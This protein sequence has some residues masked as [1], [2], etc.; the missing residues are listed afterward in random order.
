MAENNIFVNI[1]EMD[2][3]A[4]GQTYRRNNT[5]RRL[6]IY[7]QGTTRPSSSFTRIIRENPDIQLPPTNFPY[8]YNTE[9]NRWVQRRNVLDQRRTQPTLKKA[10][11]RDYELVNGRLKKKK[12]YVYSNRINYTIV[13]KP[14][15]RTLTALFTQRTLVVNSR[16][17]ITITREFVAGSVPREM[18]NEYTSDVSDT[19]P[20]DEL[21][22]FTNNIKALQQLRGDI[23]SSTFIIVRSVDSQR[24]EVSQQDIRNMRMFNCKFVLESPNM[25]NKF[26]D[27]GNLSCVPETLHWLYCNPDN[28]DRPLKLSVEDIA[29]ILQPTDYLDEPDEID[30]KQGF[31]TLD[32]KRFCQ[33]YRIPMYACD[34]FN[35]MFETYLPEKRN[36]HMKSLAFMVWG[37]HM[38]LY[39]NTQ[40][41]KRMAK[42]AD[43]KDNVS[44]GLIKGKKELYTE[45]T[46]TDK[47][48]ID[49]TDDLMEEVLN[50]YKQT[51]KILTSDNMTIVNGKITK[52]IIDGVKHFAN[53]EEEVIK[54]YIKQYNETSD[55]TIEFKNQSSM[56]FARMLWKK[57]YPDHIQSKMNT[58]VLNRFTTN[59][60]IVEKYDTTGNIQN[61]YAVD[62]NKCRTSCM[63]DN[64]LGNY[65]RFTAMDS[66]EPYENVENLREGFYYILTE[67]RLPARGNGWYSNGFINYLKKENIEYKIKYQLLA[68]DTYKEDYLM[69]MFDII[70]KYK[71][72]KFMS[73]GLIGSLA[74]KR[75][76]S[77]DMTFETDFNAACFYF[78]NADKSSY[79]L[80]GLKD[81]G[82][83]QKILCQD[84]RTKKETFIR[85]VLWNEEEDKPSLYSIES[86]SYYHMI[87]NDIPIYNQILENEWIKCYKL[88]KAMG[89]NLIQ[90]KTDCVQVEFPKATLDDEDDQ[91]I[92]GI[93]KADSYEVDYVNK[94]YNEELDI[95]FKE[96][97]TT[98]EQDYNGMEDIAKTIIDSDKSCLIHGKA[99]VGKSY[100]LRH[101]VKEL[102]KQGKKYAVLAP[103]NKASLNVNGT[104]IHKFLGIAEDNKVNGSML[105]K[106][107]SYD[108]L[109]VDE[110]SMVG[111]SLLSYLQL[112]KQQTNNLKLLF[113]GD[114]KRQLLPVCEEQY[115]YEN[116]YLMK[117]LCSFN[118]LELTINKRSD[119][120]MMKLSDDAFENGC[121]NKNDFGNFNIWKSNRHICFTNK[122]RK[123]INDIIMH[124]KKGDYLEIQC[125]D[126]DIKKNEYAQNVKIHVGTPIMSCKNCKKDGIV[127]NEEFVVDKWDDEFVYIDNDKKIEITK[128]HS[129]YVVSY[130]MTTHKSQ[131]QT[132]DFKY[133]IWEYDKFT[134]RMLYTALTRTTNKDNI[135]FAK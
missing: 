52:M 113:F 69:K 94:K 91:N 110:I 47:D 68:S 5:G 84:G 132:F 15:R 90:I 76:T 65:K 74:I 100:M 22:R 55:E 31:T 77:S 105:R 120:I 58:Q 8:L 29:E 23:Q 111:C 56:N 81:E 98:Y 106:M 130:A 26:K 4:D 73:N 115:D 36:R 95:T 107:K 51:G 45:E 117:W 93:K 20:D 123:R 118:K 32:I 11:A 125:S 24:V 57:A 41:I 43:M 82:K 60:G 88:R 2:Y 126:D 39:D 54:G 10:Y 124:N 134:P 89:G 6:N 104:T 80:T 28:C 99:G 75:K 21:Q 135:T 42:I 12:E 83:K 66:I 85:P 102:E 49:N 27:T 19:M 46:I 35:Y 40:F 61:S 79:R 16:T 87:E 1:R 97:N 14:S 122:T 34:A 64:I 101:I 18:L 53:T 133:T 96:W 9:T 129:Q 37:N 63:R 108:Y 72:F 33:K 128:F 13:T 25:S 92:G 30:I 17:P 7:R 59:A 103:T 71:D 116:S 119:D 127:N 44:S 86:R 78:W 109:L 3:S 131:G 62:I 48:I 50:Y 112:A 114:L 67:N 38:Y 121:I 70:T